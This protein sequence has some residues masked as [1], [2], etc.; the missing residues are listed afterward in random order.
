MISATTEHWPSPS[1]G[2]FSLIGRLE[3]PGSLDPMNILLAEADVIASRQAIGQR[4]EWRE[5]QHATDEHGPQTLN[6]RDL[7]ANLDSLR[8]ES[9][10]GAIA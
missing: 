4:C 9:D 6:R 3:P 7:G 1:G 10:P 8:E 2:G 5:A